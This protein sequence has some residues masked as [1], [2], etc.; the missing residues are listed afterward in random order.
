MRLRIACAAT[1]AVALGG[2]TPA[3]ARSVVARATSPATVVLFAANA[4]TGT[5]EENKQRVYEHVGPWLERAGHHVIVADYPAGIDAGLAAA[6]AAVR[7]AIRARP[8]APVCLYGE[9]SGGHLALLAAE[10]IPDVDCVATLAAPVD[11]GHWAQEAGSAPDTTQA[12]VFREYVEPALG[13]DMARWAAFDPVRRAS[14]LPRL[15]L[16]MVGADDSLVPRDQLRRLP[17]AH[18][19]LPTGPL[20]FLHGTSTAAGQAELARRVLGLVAR[21]GVSGRRR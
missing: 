14:R 5:T 19:V 13:P 10:A 1:L 16:T 3:A 2:A 8:G 11:L 7:E 21:A 17:G 15:L 18:Y 6:K 12:L 4:W 9:S 20:P